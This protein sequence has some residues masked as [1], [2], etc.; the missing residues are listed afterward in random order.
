M[1]FLRSS[2]G[3]DL[4]AEIRGEQVGLRQPTMA[5]YPAW[6]QLRALSRQHLMPWEPQWSR[7]EL[8]RSAFRR[9]LRQYQRE[10]RDDQG[11]AF[12]IV[13]HGDGTL[14]G[15]ITL[16]NVR[17]GVAQS[18]AVGYWIGVPFVRRGYMT[19]AVGAA[20]RFAFSTL[21]LHRL[22]AACLPHN[23]PSA[24]VLEKSGFK[25]EGLARQYLKINGAWQDH[26]LYALLHADRTQD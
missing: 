6:A 22:E 21:G 14:L 3:F 10:L 17:R 23:T 13:Q 2:S 18:A 20:K 4:D 19:D 26:D 1:A 5:D 9:R 24:R 11:Y 8:S 7:D 15:S 12:F 16:S 25:L